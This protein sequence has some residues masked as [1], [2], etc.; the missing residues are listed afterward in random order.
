[1]LGDQAINSQIRSIFILLAKN[2]IG[3]KKPT[4]DGIKRKISDRVYNY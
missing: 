2:I 4:E 1:M 3:N